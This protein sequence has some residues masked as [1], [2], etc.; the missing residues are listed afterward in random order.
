MVLKV[1]QLL[2]EDY[3]GFWSGGSSHY[4]T[5]EGGPVCL[6][7]SAEADRA[8]GQLRALLPRLPCW[9]IRIPLCRS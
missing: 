5:A 8:F 2:P 4:L 3:P 6:Q 1:C 7:W 9:L